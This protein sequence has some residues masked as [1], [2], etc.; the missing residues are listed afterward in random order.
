MSKKYS[1]PVIDTKA[2]GA[3]IK[4]LREH[5]GVSVREMQSLFN[6]E[7]PQAVYKW[8]WGKSLPTVDEFVVLSRMFD[9]PI[10]K[11]IVIGVE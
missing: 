6:F 2:T 4:R 5:A 9:T 7:S 11:I 10:E 8:Q 1:Y 3:N